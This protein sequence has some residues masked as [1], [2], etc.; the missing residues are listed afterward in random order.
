MVDKFLNSDGQSDVVLPEPISNSEVKH[1]YVLY[2]TALTRGKCRKLS[3]F[4]FFSRCIQT[5][6]QLHLAHVCTYWHKE[7]SR[8]HLCFFS[9]TEKKL[10]QQG[11]I[12]SF[13][14]RRSP[15]SKTSTAHILFQQKSSFN[16]IQVDKICR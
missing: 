6:L 8:I 10:Q 2:C 12:V 15:C 4:I 3:A 16:R 11:K 7:L 5:S 1:I 13:K 9:K 14:N